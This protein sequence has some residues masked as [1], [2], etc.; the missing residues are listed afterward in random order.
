[1]NTVEKEENQENDKQ[2]Y[3]FQG[4]GYDVTFSTESKNGGDVLTSIMKFDQYFMYA[5]DS[6]G[7]TDGVSPPCGPDSV[8]ASCKDAMQSDTA[9]CTLV[10]F[11]DNIFSSESANNNQG[12]NSFYRCMN[13]KIIDATFDMEID[14]MKISMACTKDSSSVYFTTSLIAS[15]AALISVSVF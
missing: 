10:D 8:H 6:M 12:H 4:D 7:M 9:C 13:T 3:G 15:I 14:G 5:I 11:E 1:M 2:E